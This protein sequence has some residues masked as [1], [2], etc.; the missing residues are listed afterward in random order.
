MSEH[1][2]SFQA[3]SR[4]VNYGLFP[5]RQQEEGGPCAEASGAA[6]RGRQGECGAPDR[7]T[8]PGDA[9]YDL[10]AALHGRARR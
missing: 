10:T 7:E 5:I 4:Y 9:G 3:F 2:A 6:G 8:L 1:R